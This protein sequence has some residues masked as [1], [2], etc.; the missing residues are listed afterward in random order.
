MAKS[1]Q[2]LQD[3]LTANKLAFYAL[4]DTNMMEVKMPAAPNSPAPNSFAT[5][6]WGK[7]TNEIFLL[8]QEMPIP[9]AD[10]QYQLWAMIGGQPVDAGTFDLKNDFTLIKLKKI[11]NAEAF[12]VTL[13][14]KGG[15]SSPSMEQMYVYG[16]MKKIEG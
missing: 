16:S 7:K 9:A 10:K 3:D 13:E 15:S 11:R 2:N 5:V 4:K 12:A 14:N 6:Y 1:I 8:V